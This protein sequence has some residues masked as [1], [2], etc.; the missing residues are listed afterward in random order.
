MGRPI[1]AVIAVAITG[2]ALL[3]CSDAHSGRDR[4]AKR[5]P[6]VATTTTTPVGQPAPGASG[7]PVTFAFAGDVHFVDQLADKVNANP[8]Q[9]LAPIAPVLSGADFAMVNLET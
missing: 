1:I 2:G 5:R 6:T 8:T 7:Q 9:V 3:G 4:A